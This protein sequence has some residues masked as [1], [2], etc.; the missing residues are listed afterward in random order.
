MNCWLCS[1]AVALPT[2]AAPAVGGHLLLRPRRASCENINGQSD[3][4]EPRFSITEGSRGGLSQRGGGGGGE[5]K[6]ALAMEAQLP[7]A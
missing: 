6:Q 3:V 4:E 7:G 5:G 1:T 2:R